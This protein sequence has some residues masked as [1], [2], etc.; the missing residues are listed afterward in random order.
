MIPRA[1]PYLMGS[2]GK[3]LLTMTGEILPNDF[4]SSLLIPDVRGTILLFILSS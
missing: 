3:C 4:P 1:T 2:R